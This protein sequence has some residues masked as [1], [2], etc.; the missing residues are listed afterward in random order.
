MSNHGRH[1]KT[2]SIKL[3]PMG[4]DQF[5]VR[6]THRGERYS[7]TDNPIG[8]VAKNDRG[9]WSCSMAHNPGLGPVFGDFSSKEKAAQDCYRGHKSWV[10]Y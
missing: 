1:A 2:V 9:T 6:A 5:Q 8:V 3:V 4:R 10:G 7:Y